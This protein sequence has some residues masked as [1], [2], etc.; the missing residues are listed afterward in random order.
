MAEEPANA[1]SDGAGQGAAAGKGKR[2]MLI[3]GILAG[4][5]LAEGVGLYAVMKVFG[6]G[7][8]QAPAAEGMFALEEGKDSAKPEIPIVTIKVPNRTTGKTYLYDVEV[9][10]TLN[11]P[12][13]KAPE[14]FRKTVM[15]QLDEREN[16]VRDR[17]GFLIRSAEPQHLNEPGLVM[18]RRQIKAELGKVMGNET[19]FD[20]ILLPRWT[21]LRADM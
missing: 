19:L 6:A 5:M 14:E 10:A 8:Q 3:G 15:E 2:S 17:I 12:N 9:A 18:M 4:V 13:G 11:V 1:A 20:E 21:P 16:A 7:P